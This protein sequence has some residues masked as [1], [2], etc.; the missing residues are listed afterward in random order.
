[1]GFILCFLAH[2]L[3]RGLKF[4][5]AFLLSF[6][7]IGRAGWQAGRQADTADKHGDHYDNYWN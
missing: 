5:H 2:E 4:D 6:A 3:I 1:L 7:P